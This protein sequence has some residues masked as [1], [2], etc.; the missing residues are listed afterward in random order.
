MSR[1][2]DLETYL[3]HL[4]WALAELPAEDRDEIVRETRSHFLDRCEG[5]RARPFAEVARELGSAEEYGRRFRANYNI[6][7]ALGSGS[8]LRM[9]YTAASLVGRS[10]WATGGFFVFIVLYFL[11]AS[12]VLVAVLKPILPDRVGLWTS[13]AR[14]LFVL[15]VVAS[16]NDPTLREHLGWW[17]IPLC[18][19]GAVLLYW[20]TTALLRRFLRTLRNK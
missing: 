15:G 7:V 11:T 6:S 8:A 14:P 4:R 1:E 3:K 19:A 10:L 16:S 20:G 13:T 5:P 2:T 17:V 12:F 18:L 9:L